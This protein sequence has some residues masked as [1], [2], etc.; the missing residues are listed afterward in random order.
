MRSGTRWTRWLCIAVA[1]MAALAAWCS[2]ARA[3]C[4]PD[5]LFTPAG[6]Y[7][8]DPLPTFGQFTQAGPPRQ[9]QLG[10]KLSF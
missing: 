10:A 3:Q 1:H 6:A 8:T 7:P 9:L 2:N 5:S 4:S